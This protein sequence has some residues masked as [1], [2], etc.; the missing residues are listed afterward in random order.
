MEIHTLNC[1]I[2]GSH[3]WFTRLANLTPPQHVGVGGA[4][5][6]PHFINLVLLGLNPIGS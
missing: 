3:A 1:V 6:L 5:R 4:N 2:L